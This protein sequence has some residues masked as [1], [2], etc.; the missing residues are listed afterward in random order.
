MNTDI[1][2]V[3]PWVDGS[4]T[5]WREQFNK[6]A[7]RN[8]DSE[9]IRF[10]DWELLRYWFRSI[11]K[12]TPWFRK[13]HFITSGEL[14][15]WLN[16]DHP[17]LHWVKHEDY[18]PKEYLPTFSSHTIELNMHRIEGLSGRFVYFNDDFFITRPLKASRFFRKGL[19]CD[20]PIMTAKPSSGGIIHIAINNLEILEK[21]FDKH[22]VIK[23]Y[24]AKWYSPKYGQRLINNILLFPWKEFSGFVEPHIP[25]AFLKSTLID[26]WNKEPES[27]IKTCQNKFR[28]NEDINQWL[29][30][31]WQFANGCFYPM[32]IQRKT[33][34]TDINDN[35]IGSICRDIYEQKYDM[36]CL[37]DSTDISDFEDCRSRL[38]K[39][40][41]S[42]L[43]ESSAFEKY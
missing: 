35:L 24:F 31:Y 37:N 14:P 20:A 30:R 2:F 28:T 25:Y 1:D 12:F 18:I 27:L 41:D 22:P 29:I 34:C 42:I 33:R 13:I 15:A 11:E 40:F 26:M 16:L 43:P 3:L 23:K 17:Q 19:P 4:D 8:G 38:Q 32:D 36:I 5:H 21:H 10:R 9:E 39:A 7:S 6:Y